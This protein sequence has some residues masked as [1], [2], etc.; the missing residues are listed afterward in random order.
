MIKLNA[1]LSMMFTEVEF[2][3]RF[4]QAANAGFKGV[5]YLFPYAFAMDQIHQQ[6]LDHQLQQVLFNLPAGDWESGERGIAS[7]PDRVSEFREGVDLA[8]EYATGLGCKQCNALAGIVSDAGKTEV[9]TETFIENLKFAAPRM[10]E[11]GIKLLI[12]A[13]NTRDIPGFYLNNTAQVLSILNEVNCD[14]LYYQYD[15]YH[16]Q[17]ME[18]DLAITMEKNLDKI[19][20]M[21]LA[22][23]PG[24]HEPGTGEINYS[25]LFQHL[26]S[27][28]YQGWIGCEYLPRETTEK[29]LSWMQEHGIVA[30]N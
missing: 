30:G 21:Q 15:I 25:F 17:I 5:E 8:I 26:E 20:H 9:A 3:E 1:N 12:E 22:D 19:A 16:M 2:M 18:G 4:K 24:R 23:N 10:E 29:G 28:G 27:I 14:N 6:L 7:H 11:A 13:I